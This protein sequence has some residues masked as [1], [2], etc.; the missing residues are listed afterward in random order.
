MVPTVRRR[1]PRAERQEQIL[2]VAYES[3]VEFGYDGVSMRDIAG[4]AGVTKPILYAHHGSKDGLFAACVERMVDPMLQH[5]R[6]A[7]DP[8]LS[9]DGQLWAGILAQLGFIDEH[10]AEWRVFV[11]EAG[12][13][14]G[15]PGAALSHGRDR[16]VALLAEL[17]EQATST[18]GS[19]MPPS[20]EI[21]ALAHM[22][23]GTVEQIANWW[24]RHPEERLE[25]VALRA[26]NFTWQGFGDLGEARIWRPPR[27]RE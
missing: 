13:R 24:E 4:R 12:A 2:A 15:L 14:G 1:L 21:E 25:S 9:A 16:V 3:F 18:T 5:V 26:M 19:P 7:T 27:P 22:L 20:R 11:R 23:Q 6:S 10:R 17:I 8:S